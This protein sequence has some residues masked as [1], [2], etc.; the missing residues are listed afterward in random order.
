MKAKY[1]SFVALI[2]DIIVMVLVI[3]GLCLTW[4]KP[5]DKLP[6]QENF[7]INHYGST[8]LRFTC[9]SGNIFNDG[10][11]VYQGSVVMI[12]VSSTA[13]FTILF[14][15]IFSLAQFLDGHLADKESAEGDA[16]PTTYIVVVSTTH[17]ALFFQLLVGVIA[18]V[19]GSHRVRKDL[20]YKYAAGW[21]IVLVATCI[22]FC[23]SVMFFI[24]Q[25]FVSKLLSVVTFFMQVFSSFSPFGST[26]MVIGLCTSFY[27]TPSS[28]VN[29][30]KYKTLGTV[31][32]LKDFCGKDE[33]EKFC[34]LYKSSATLIAFSVAGLLS[35]A[36]ITDYAGKKKRII[37]SIASFVFLF[38]GF[39]Q[40]AVVGAKAKDHYSLHYGLG[41]IYYLTGFIFMSIGLALNIIRALLISSDDDKNN[42]NN[43]K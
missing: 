42:N 30:L 26:L 6:G 21:I 16:K 29:A 11:L 34:N 37:C 18:Y 27:V 8:G 9:K 38:V 19:I 12:I 40:Y 35:S 39:V 17:L 15:A 2:S 5:G 28:R 24:A 20:N 22:T 25:C 23:V 41:W 4:L 3:T 10:C 36:V 33:G 32:N 31:T 13:L 14:V 7:K 1:L 43:N